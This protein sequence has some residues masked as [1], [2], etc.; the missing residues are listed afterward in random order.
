MAKGSLGAWS[1]DLD[2]NGFR[3]TAGYVLGPNG[4]QITEVDGQGAWVHTNVYAAGQLIATYA[5]DTQGVHLHLNDWLRTRR[6]TLAYNGQPQLSCASLPFGDQLACTGT[7]TDPTEQHFSGKERDTE[8]GLDYFGARYMSS[9][10]GRFSSPDPSGI[11]YADF[12]NPQTLNLYSYVVNNPLRYVDPT[13]LVLCDYGS[14]DQGG[15]DYEDADN[16]KECTSNGG[17]V[18]NVH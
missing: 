7:A 6:M 8:S 1:C 9:N 13:G 10:M 11:D 17:S 5:N 18:V 16:N 14:S 12:S 2:S 4:E 3:E 15:N